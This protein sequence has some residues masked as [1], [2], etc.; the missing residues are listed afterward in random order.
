MR[1]LSVPSDPRK[2]R[3]DFDETETLL[4]LPFVIYLHFAV[5]LRSLLRRWIGREAGTI[6]GSGVIVVVGGP[7]LLLGCATLLLMRLALTLLSALD[8]LT[9]PRRTAT[10]A[11]QNSPARLRLRLTAERQPYRP[12]RH[13]RSLKPSG[14]SRR[15]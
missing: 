14:P 2:T 6:V 12:P 13:S 8:Q 4:L 3:S 10:R 5:R 1:P 9:R 11:A 7:P 15:R